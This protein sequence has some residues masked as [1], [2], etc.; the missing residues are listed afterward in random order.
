[1]SRRALWR[2]P[3]ATRIVAVVSFEASSVFGVPV[4]AIGVVLAVVAPFGVR[5]IRRLID[6]RSMRRTERWLEKN[7]Q[8]AAASDPTTPAEDRLPSGS[9]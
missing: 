3:R 9:A 2:P 7:V 5:L 6:E 8:S 1:M 4:W